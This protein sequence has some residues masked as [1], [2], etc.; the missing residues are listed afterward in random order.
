M[1]STLQNRKPATPMLTYLAT[2]HYNKPVTKKIQASQACRPDVAAKMSVRNLHLQDEIDIKPI[3][4]SAAPDAKFYSSSNYL[5]PEHL[6]NIL[7]STSAA[8]SPRG[9][10][11]NIQRLQPISQ[12]RRKSSY[13]ETQRQDGFFSPRVNRAQ[14]YEETQQCLMID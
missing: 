12:S 7:S 8:T 5:K 9:G 11:Y 4:R 14:R 2:G 6:Q 1:A 3:T 13:V 10:L